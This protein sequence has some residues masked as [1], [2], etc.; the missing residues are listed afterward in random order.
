MRNWLSSSDSVRI[1]CQALG[2][3]FG[4]GRRLEAFHELS[5]AF[6]GLWIDDMLLE[7]RGAARDVRGMGRIELLHHSLEWLPG[8]RHLQEGAAVLEEV[9]IL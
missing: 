1:G 7:E 8:V 5:E 2:T 4:D 3:D 9:S 6:G